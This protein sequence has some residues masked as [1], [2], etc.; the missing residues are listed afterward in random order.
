M[1][2]LSL[3]NFSEFEIEMHE[4]VNDMNEHGKE[5]T[6]KGSN[7]CKDDPPDRQLTIKE[8]IPFLHF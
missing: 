7:P 1:A 8:A 4:G 2:S 3:A 5:R 6:G